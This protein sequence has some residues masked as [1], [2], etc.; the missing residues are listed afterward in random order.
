MFAPAGGRQLESQ[1]PLSTGLG[2]GRFQTSSHP[3]QAFPTNPTRTFGL[4]GSF[5]GSQDSVRVMNAAMT[6]GLHNP[7][8]Q[9]G[10]AAR[11]RL[12]IGTVFDI[13]DPRACGRRGGRRPRGR[14]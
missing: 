12:A 9:A 7:D 6:Q 2:Q 14:G 8:P 10:S 11:L 1:L 5:V 3:F 4:Q 13:V